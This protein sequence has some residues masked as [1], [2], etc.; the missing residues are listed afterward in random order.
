M[1]LLDVYGSD[2][3]VDGS[4]SFLATYEID[5]KNTKLLSHPPL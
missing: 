4:F 1:L 3:A 2:I 5:R